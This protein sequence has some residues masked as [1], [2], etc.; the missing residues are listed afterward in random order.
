MLNHC[1]LGGQRAINFSVDGRTHMFEDAFC[2]IQLWGMRRLLNAP[3]LQPGIGLSTVAS[4]AIPD[5]CA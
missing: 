4:P 1:H 2:G 3:D 5:Q